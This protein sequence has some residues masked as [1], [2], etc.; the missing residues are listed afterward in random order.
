MPTI[1]DDND[2]AY[3][4]WLRANPDGYVVN[5]TRSRTPSYMVLHRATCKSIGEYT[6]MAERG[7]FTERDY[8]K[9]C[10]LDSDDLRNWVSEHGRPNRSFSRECTHCN[11]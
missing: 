6:A 10:S 3:Q 5:T 11:R 4:E 2:T 7:G 8:I 9:V 1:F